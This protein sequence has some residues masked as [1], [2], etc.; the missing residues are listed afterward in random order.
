MPVFEYRG[1]NAAGKTVTGLKEADSPKTLRAVLRKD[2]IFLTDVIG[3]AEGALKAGKGKGAAGAVAAAGNKE[4]NLRRLASGGVN[5][6][7]IA[8]M[9]RQLA[10]L[11]KAGVSLVEALSAMVDQVEKEQL[12]RILSDVKQRV[13]EGSSLGDALNQHVKVFGSLFVNMIRTP[14]RAG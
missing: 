5:T 7:D 1:L 14:S 8:V 2:S 10:T 3:Q 12:K 13:N 11:L 4:I 9:T 6:D